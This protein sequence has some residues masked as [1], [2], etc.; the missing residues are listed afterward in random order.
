MIDGVQIGG[1]DTSTPHNLAKRVALIDSVAGLRHRRV[2]D[3][4]CGAGQYVEAFVGRGAD[5]VGVEFNAEKV[6]L[7]R[8]H[9]P[10]SNRVTQGDLVALPFPVA[11]FDVVVLNEV[12]EHTPDQM[13]VLREIHRVLCGK[14]VLVLFSPNRLYPFET[15]GVRWRRTGRPLTPW[16][17]FVPYV[18]LALGR[19]VFVYP[20]RN[21]WPCELSRLIAAAGFQIAGRRWLWQTFENIS[22][23][24]PPW[25]TRLGP[26]LRLFAGWLE[27]CP[28]LRCFGVSQVVLAKKP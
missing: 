8:Q 5:A 11:S 15:H 18:P 23:Q 3:A 26:G 19:L 24:Q 12:L 14:G 13:R 21:Y 2:L 27:Y 25:V 1:G 6:S 16:L 9:Q 4:G 7:Y 28:G 22:G 20:A 17:P 10:G